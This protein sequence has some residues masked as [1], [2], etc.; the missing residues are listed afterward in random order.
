MPWSMILTA[1]PRAMTAKCPYKHP[2]GALLQSCS[3]HIALGLPFFD[4]KAT[5]S[6]SVKV[7]MRTS[8]IISKALQ[9]ATFYLTVTNAAFISSEWTRATEALIKRAVTFGD[10]SEDIAKSSICTDDQRKLLEQSMVEAAKL[11]KAGSDGLS[12]ILNMLTDEK[13]E[14][15]ALPTADRNRIRE[16]YFTFFGRITKKAE[17]DL[18]RSRANS[19]K[20]VLDRVSPLRT[21]SWPDQITFFCDSTYYQDKDPNGDTWDQVSPP[22]EAPAK[23]SRVWKYD[24]HLSIW[25]EVLQVTD[26]NQSGTQVAAYTLRLRGDNNGGKDMPSDRITFCPQWFNIV[27]APEAGK[28]FTDLDPKVDIQEGTKMSAFARKAARV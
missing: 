22:K 9:Y 10:I 12:V 26:C 20:T 1:T 25:S 19:I 17:F 24:Y 21:E 27:K 15:R 7:S 23:A 28:S 18:F 4:R 16:S 13:T 5:I 11:A 3:T 8:S 2:Y 14:Y 6:A